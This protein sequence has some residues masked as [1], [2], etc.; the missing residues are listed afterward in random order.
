MLSENKVSRAISGD[1]EGA[2]GRAESTIIELKGAI[3]LA[4]VALFIR[5]IVASY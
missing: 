4:L 5:A 2:K 3:E 1:L